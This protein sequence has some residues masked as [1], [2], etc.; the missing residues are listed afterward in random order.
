[1]SI[2]LRFTFIFVVVIGVLYFL[3][4]GIAVAFGRFPINTYLIFAAIE[5]GL[6]SVLG[7]LSL[8]RRAVS[9]SDIRSLEIESLKEIVETTRKAEELDRARATAE[10][11]ID[12]LA[13]QK[14]Q[15][16]I[17]VRKASLSLF[18]Q[19]QWKLYERRI[20]EEVDGNRVLMSN[21]TELISIDERLSVL[22]EEIETD[23]NVEYL[24][25]IIES[26][27]TRSVSTGELVASIDSPLLR[28]IVS[29]SKFLSDSVRRS[30]FLL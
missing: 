4:G 17:L 28:G 19:E 20:L 3:V 24:K 22:D 14:Q 6:A 27:M 13:L 18:L 9:M 30:S 1:M 10:Q 29:I 21:L 16:E 7:L 12:N 5:G 2:I 11:E 23:P 25:E 8:G 15:M 26:G